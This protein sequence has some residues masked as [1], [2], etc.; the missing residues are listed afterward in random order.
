[1]KL[2]SIT[3]RSDMLKCMLCHN[4]PCD[5]ACPHGVEPEKILRH[6]WFNN[7]NYTAAGRVLPSRRSVP[8]K[9]MK[10]LPG[11]QLLRATT[12]ASSVSRI[13][14]SFRTTV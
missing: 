8:L 9:Y 14:N 3:R 4:A 11:F 1:M 7:E 5:T 13:L 10:R 2:H 12:E 6:I